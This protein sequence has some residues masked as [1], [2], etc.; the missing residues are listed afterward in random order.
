MSQS[1]AQFSISIPDAQR[2][3]FR[4]LFQPDSLSD[5]DSLPN[6]CEIPDLQE[7]SESIHTVE[8][9]RDDRIVIQT[10]LK[11]KIP[12]VRIREVL[13][14]TESQIEYARKHRVTPQKSKTG[15]KPLLRTPQR[16]CLE[17][18]LLESPSHQQIQFQ[19]IPQHMPEF[20][21]IGEKAIK[22]AFNLLDYCW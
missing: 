6:S 22:T 14:V 7:S 17:Q 20:E 13:G 1:Q 5:L 2:D 4:E 11:F 15:R 3:L 8:T 19:D 21:D 18:W 12:H 9:T 16:N 10:A